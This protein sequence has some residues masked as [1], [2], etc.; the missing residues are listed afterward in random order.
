MGEHSSKGKCL[1]TKMTIVTN[2]Y[3]LKGDYLQQNLQY[4]KT[5][6]FE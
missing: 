4:R 1:T 3:K 6:E 2:Q 5:L